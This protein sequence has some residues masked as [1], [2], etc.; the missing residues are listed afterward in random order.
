ME[1]NPEKNKNILQNPE[2]QDAIQK[3]LKNIIIIREL[4]DDS[5]KDLDDFIQHLEDQQ[6]YIQTI[7][8]VIDGGFSTFNQEDIEKIRDEIN[9]TKNEIVKINTDI[10]KLI[11]Y[12]SVLD[13]QIEEFKTLE[14]KFKYILLKIDSKN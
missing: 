14:N 13:T 4:S 12:K 8:E 9:K 3:S 10:S 6:N 5:L 2:I 11:L 7:K 1:Q